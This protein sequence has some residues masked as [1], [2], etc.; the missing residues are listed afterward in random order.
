MDILTICIK[1]ACHFA[2][3]NYFPFL[4]TYVNMLYCKQYNDD[5]MTGKNS[6]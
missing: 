2:Y 4:F 6:I 3:I 1:C 5:F